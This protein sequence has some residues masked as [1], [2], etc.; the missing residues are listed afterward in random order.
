M[1]Q[2]TLMMNNEGYS[3]L[4]CC[5][6]LNCKCVSYIDTHLKVEFVKISGL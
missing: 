2:Q 4:M 5:N 3:Q 1:K 6:E